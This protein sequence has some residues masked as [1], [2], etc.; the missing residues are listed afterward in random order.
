MQ[1]RSSRESIKRNLIK[2]M[3][4]HRKIPV[5]APLAYLLIGLIVG[6]PLCKTISLPPLLLLCAALILIII[7]LKITGRTLWYPLFIPA[8]ILTAWAYGQ[9]RLPPAPDAEL[10]QLPP[11][12]ACLELKIQRIFQ[13]SDRYGKTSGLAKVIHAEKESRLQKGHR[14]Y[15]RLSTKNSQLT[16]LYP[17]QIIRSTAVL[18]PI[19][20]KRDKGR[21]FE[22]YLNS[23]GV[24]HRFQRNGKIETIGK[25]PP[26]QIF[27]RKMNEKFQN[28]LLLD[29]PEGSNTSGIYLAML[30]G[31]KGELDHRQETAF[32]ATGTM[33]LFAISGLHIGVIAAVLAQAL[34]LIR[35]PG[36]LSPLIALPA[37]FLYVGITGASP[38]SVRAFLMT[39][40]YWASFTCQRQRSPFAA[41]I[42]SAVFVLILQPEQL[43]SAGF[44]LSYAVVLSILLFGLPLHQKLNGL[45]SPFQSLPMSSWKWRHHLI[46]KSLSGTCLLFSIS[47]SAWLASTPFTAAYFG[48]ISPGAILLNMLMVNLASLV[49]IGG[50]CSIACSL[51]PLSAI[52]SFINHA[53]WVNLSLMETLVYWFKELPGAFLTCEYFSLPLAYAITTLYFILLLHHHSKKESG[54]LSLLFAPAATLLLL[55]AGYAFSMPGTF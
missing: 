40:F 1:V 50:V 25:I 37:L 2:D 52:S 44:Q 3:K 6:L 39:T 7:A 12:E 10:N 29:A 46:E 9:I 13:E 15:F 20:M 45:I 47:L 19:E 53:A 23:L 17:G 28:T 27:Y 4:N 5:D 51:L 18:T 30:L 38:S 55:T 16:T 32:Q 54:F 31:L 49:I 36:W 43:W 41:L 26:A 22:D 33:H 35:I 11:R 14:I 48:I 24:Y 21:D 42:G 8:A 34:Q